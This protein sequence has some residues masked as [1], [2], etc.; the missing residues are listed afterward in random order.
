VDLIA[1]EPHRVRWVA[2][3]GTQ[4]KTD[5]KP[6]AGELSASDQSHAVAALHFAS[7]ANYQLVL[8]KQKLH[9]GHSDGPALVIDAQGE[10]RIVLNQQELAPDAD[11]LAGP[12]LLID[13][14]LQDLPTVQSEGK[15][16]VA[17][18]T[19]KAGALLLATGTDLQAMAKALQAAGAMRAIAAPGHEGGW[20]R[21]SKE[22]PLQS[23]Y[24][25][26][27]LYAVATPLAPRAFR[28][29][30]DDADQPKWPPVTKAVP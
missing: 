4:D 23:W 14:K 20:S 17:V 24:P 13:G 9:V 18:G 3:A 25:L 12:A 11:V 30:H 6:D 7:S 27:T 8:Q 5:G 2:R 22:S 15:T 19:T 21:A 16:L 28:W 26:T 29:D 10:A 1:I